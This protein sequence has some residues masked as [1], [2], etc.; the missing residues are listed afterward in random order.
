MI[1]CSEI[2]SY[3]ALELQLSMESMLFD[4][5]SHLK[6][7]DWAT[8]RPWIKV[9]WLGGA[10]T[11]LD[12]QDPGGS[13]CQ[14]VFLLDF[15]RMSPH[16]D[17]QIKL[18]LQNYIETSHIPPAFDTIQYSLTF[19]L[20]IISICSNSQPLPRY[21]EHVIRQLFVPNK[22]YLTTS[23]TL[24][25]SMYLFQLPTPRLWHMYLASSHLLT[26]YRTSFEML[27]LV[28]KHKHALTFNPTK[29]NIHW[30]CV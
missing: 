6:V 29:K 18:L 23:K 26:V 27:P 2:K 16:V 15:N 12:F 21:L 24:L 28:D 8:S 5:L 7:Y 25:F 20:C 9:A 3:I 19:N 30:I 11:F 13:R 4:D 1:L 22:V 17:A 10:L 14:L